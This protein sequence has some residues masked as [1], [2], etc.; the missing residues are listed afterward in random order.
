MSNYQAIIFDMNG[1]IIDDEPLHVQ[2][3]ILTC[4][5]FGLHVPQEE[6]PKI[7][8]WKS[9]EIFSYFANA[10]ADHEIDINDM[11]AMKVDEYLKLAK[12]QAQPVVGAVDFV[13]FSRRKFPKVALAT[14]TLK[15]LQEFTFNRFGL[16]EYF[17][18]I[19]TAEDLERGKPDPDSYLK[20]AAK[21]GVSA[22]ECL[23]IEDSINGIM[24]GKRAGC[25]VLSIPTSF[26][27]AELTAAGADFVFDSF[28][29]AVNNS[30]IW[31]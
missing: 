22:S 24:S 5:K 14:S 28:A 17:D 19:I 1:V 29:E 16:K 2:S 4:E 8:G 9:F 27:T 30:N 7:K 25:K 11:I 21:L 6:W 15:V 20:A 10:Y 23:V 26:S 18:A 3:D 13:K 12:D 31:L